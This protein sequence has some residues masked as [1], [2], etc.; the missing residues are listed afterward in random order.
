MSKLALEFLTSLNARGIF[1]K[2]ADGKLAIKAKKGALTPEDKERLQANKAQII[3]LLAADHD[4]KKFS[5]FGAHKIELEVLSDRLG[6][7]DDIYPTTSMQSSMLLM[8]KV[9]SQLSN[10]NLQQYCTLKDKNDL[11]ALKKA[12]HDTIARH[13][14]LRTVFSQLDGKWMQIVLK[15]V[16]IN[17]IDL[18]WRAPVNDIDAALIDYRLE[19][20]EKRFDFDGGSMHRVTSITLPDGQV[21][22]LWTIHH[23]LVDGMSL[24]RVM[25]EVMQSA[26][27]G[28]EP[29]TPS[30]SFAEYIADTCKKPQDE[31]IGF[32]KKYLLGASEP[33]SFDLKKEEDQELVS[34]AFEI[35]SLIASK[36]LNDIKTVARDL[37]VSINSVISAAWSYM[38][39]RYSGLDD[40]IFGT[41]VSGK[42]GLTKDFS[43][44][45][46][47]FINTLPV[48]VIFGANHT[49]K[50]VI[51]SVHQSALS[52]SDYEH[53][54]LSEIKNASDMKGQV[55]F[56]NIVV[57]QDVGGDSR[58]DSALPLS[59]AG[60]YGQTNF[61]I[62]LLVEMS[63][64]DILLTLKSHTQVHDKARIGLL[65]EDFKR[66][67]LSISSNIDENIVDSEFI[68]TDKQDVH[69]ITS[70]E[71]KGSILDLIDFTTHDIA[72]ESAEG[73][74]TYSALG[75]KVD[76][77]SQSLSSAGIKHGDFVGVESSTDANW[78]ISLLAVMKVG[79]VYTPIDEPQRADF[80]HLLSA[81][82]ATDMSIIKLQGRA[83]ADSGIAYCLHTSGTTGSK[84]AIQVSHKQLM[85]LISNQAADQPL[86]GET[87][88]TLQFTS[89]HFDVSLQEVFTALSTQ[90]PLVLLPASDRRDFEAIIA[91]IQDAQIARLFVPY[92]ILNAF[93]S[94]VM[95]QDIDLDSLQVIITAG[96]QLKITDDIADFFDLHEDCRLINHYGPAE[97]HV[98]TAF[99]LPEMSFQW[100]S[101][102]PI[103]K[104]LSHVETI[105]L[106]NHMR[107]A[108]QGVKGQLGIIWNEAHMPYLDNAHNMDKVKSTIKGQEQLRVYMT[109]DIV[110]ETLQGDFLYIGRNDNQV[111]INGIRVSLSDIE[112]NI[113][114]GT[115]AKE[116]VVIHDSALGL[117]SYI[118]ADEG[119]DVQEARNALREL[120][121]DHMIPRRWMILEALPITVNGKLDMKKVITLPAMEKKYQPIKP[122]TKTECAVAEIWEDVMAIESVYVNDNFFDL[123]GHSLMMMKIKSRIQSR[124]A[125]SLED[126]V[127]FE[128]ATVEE[129][130]KVIDS[131]K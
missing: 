77:L 24:S 55:L 106:D 89:K 128:N 5:L 22:V 66:L 48:R 121:P 118:A 47:I 44:A 114:K 116:C 78:L 63:D 30:V 60:S 10:Y 117:T 40:V 94:V 82:I 79:G 12:M 75:E 131:M 71:S 28:L 62:T 124:F 56:D 33:S 120:L 18:E 92:A 95:D 101:L 54:D 29:E 86:L 97:T 31:A 76:A 100:S 90:S 27:L 83:Q 32:W 88:K 3:A 99:T 102:P 122:S 11:D 52:R 73:T 70:T 14:S 20:L 23:A 74:L 127:F 72:V 53:I 4:Y 17:W 61:P 68:Y 58:N 67:L 59:D 113:L 15:D 42:N 123:G 103:G 13:P 80:S 46:G 84:K 35:K 7:I 93:A 25:N 49:L 98:V 111:K 37:K 115:E 51:Y 65:M 16:N 6:A 126:D 57:F 19:D 81:V 9:S 45:V 39:H 96:E 1:V 119:F 109:G 125:I 91:L 8:D 26:F 129:L 64:N 85:S 108:P 107:R 105:V 36:E 21:F 43:D 112:A 110:R 130:S 104:P 38:L 41:T 34:E 2:H 50:D 69:T 87:L